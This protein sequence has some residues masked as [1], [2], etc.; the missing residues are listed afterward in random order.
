M[1][2]AREIILI[3]RNAIRNAPRDVLLD[4]VFKGRM[5]ESHSLVAVN[6]A[7]LARRETEALAFFI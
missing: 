1:A 2:I 6:R 4:N 5:S 3:H 7:E